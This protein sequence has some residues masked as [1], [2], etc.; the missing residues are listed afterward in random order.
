MTQRSTQGKLQT[1]MLMILLIC[2]I[3]IH[4]QTWQTW[5][6]N[7]FDKLSYKNASWP[8]ITLH[9]GTPYVAYDEEG[10]YVK[11][12]KAD[13]SGW[14]SIGGGKLSGAVGGGS[15]LNLRFS[16]TT[17]YV[18]YKHSATSNRGIVRLFNGTTWDIV[19]GSPFSTTAADLICFEFS[20]DNTPYVFY[21]ENNLLTVKKFNGTAWENV[22]T[23]GFGNG[24]DFS[25]AFQGNMPYVSYRDT[26]ASNGATVKKFNG[27]SWETVGVAGFGL[28]AVGPGMVQYTSLAFDGTTPYIAYASFEFGYKACVRKFN[29]TNWE[30]VGNQGF[31]TGATT[32]VSLLISNG[33]PYVAYKDDA[34]ANG[35]RATV[36]KFDGT[37]W[38]TAGTE[39][40]STAPAYNLS[41]S[42]DGTTPYVAY[43]SGSSTSA[44]NE[45]VVMK[46][47]NT[48]AG[49]ERVGA[50]TN[51]YTTDALARF[52]FNGTTPYIYYKNQNSKG[53]VRKFNGQLWES[54]GADGFT[55]GSLNNYF[56]LTFNN[57]NTPYVGYVNNDNGN[58]FVMKYNGTNWEDVGSSIATNVIPL[59][60]HFD[61]TNAPIMVYRQTV[62]NNHSVVMKKYNGAS[63]QT[64]Q[65]ASFLTGSIA[66][67]SNFNVTYDNGIPSYIVY[68]DPAQSS[69][70]TVKQY[71]GSAWVTVGTE[72]FTPAA[73]SDVTI[74]VI[75]NV[76]H[77]AFRDAGASTN[78]TVMKYNGTTWELV[79]TRGFS[80][81][82]ESFPVMFEHNATLYVRYKDRVQKFDGSSWVEIGD[83]TRPTYSFGYHL[84]FRG[85]IPYVAYSDGPAASK[86][87]L[88][89]F[90]GTGNSWTVVGN[91][92]FTPSESSNITM[93]FDGD[94]ILVVYRSYKGGVFVK[95]ITHAEALPVQLIS[96]TAKAVENRSFIEWSTA[97]ETNNRM[98]V[99]SRS[100]DGI[101][102][103]EKGRV[104]AAG[105]SSNP[106]YY[107]YSDEQPLP[108]KNYY[109]LTQ[110]DADGTKKI[111]GV[112]E[113]RFDKKA[114]V[115]VYPNP[116]TGNVTAS[117]TP[118]LYRHIIVTDV[119]GKIL[120][121][122][123]LNTMSQME[124]INL[125]GKIPGIYLVKFLGENE[126]KVLKVIK[127]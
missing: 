69:K 30:A 16:G 113:V 54:V 121:Q 34:S 10:V 11:K 57:T 71:N 27:T 55:Q 52:V 86:A 90:T 83:N 65:S 98:F 89:K 75:N 59:S 48:G 5:G 66:V 37:N 111:L 22:G 17:P 72:G 38:V 60:L 67:N 124:I 44:Y 77:I 23:P 33:I 101:N 73:A 120:Q 1:L 46:L 99:I 109:K 49:W 6:P 116:S 58:L 15:F 123:S 108:G 87:T 114:D 32:F 21:K 85:N 40:F 62:S 9:N 61:N 53:S 25:L 79:G 102:F 104:N 3:L 26:D 80:L 45:A 96:Y 81:G 18:A 29:G 117:F 7:D 41:L 20:Q 43:A 94:D 39:G 42:V 106:V 14:E 82:D 84:L 12:L 8:S 68:S 19:G 78:L 105:N 126:N 50:V 97:T 2:S 51:L 13:G 103:K 107:T 24:A 74:A 119:A 110:V 92:A 31:S 47:D 76:P 70:A 118:S 28:P 122:Y 95:K 88:K 91:S 115:R 56:N 125:N 100:S 35:Q 112:R 63:W 36:K 93:A 4:A 127:K 64:I